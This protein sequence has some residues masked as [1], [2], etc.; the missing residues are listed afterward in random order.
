MGSGSVQ[1]GTSDSGSNV[2]LVLKSV[3]MAISIDTAAFCIVELATEGKNGTVEIANLG[4]EENE[5]LGLEHQ[6]GAVSLT[7]RLDFRIQSFGNLFE[8]ISAFGGRLAHGFLTWKRCLD[9]CSVNPG[10]G[11]MVES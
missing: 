4:L 2:N 1:A 9:A 3:G 7:A 8:D 6:G 10:G 11:L 5:L